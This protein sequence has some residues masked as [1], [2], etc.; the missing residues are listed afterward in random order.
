MVHEERG[1][2]GRAGGGK[3]KP[4]ATRPGAGKAAKGKGG[5]AAA[6]GRRTGRNRPAP[7]EPGEMSTPMRLLLG[8]LVVGF[9]GLGA[10]L[11]T[12]GLR[13]GPDQD[14]ARTTAG[15]MEAAT[16]TGVDASYSLVGTSWGLAAKAPPPPPE[17]ELSEEERRMR[18]FEAESGERWKGIEIFVRGRR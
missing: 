16:E 6:A 11:L 10:W 15:P 4:G 2:R 8:G 17:L 12:S 13:S 7:D 14:P 3:P 18:K 5:G 9:L 1:G